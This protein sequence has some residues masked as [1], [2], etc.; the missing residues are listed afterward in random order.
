MT[1]N[2]KKELNSNWK[3][4]NNKGHKYI[5][6][7]TE[8]ISNLLDKHNIKNIDFCT[9]DTEGGEFDIIKSFD[10]DKYNVKIFV[11]ENNYNETNIKKYLESKGYK[12]ITK[13]SIDDVFI[14]QNV[15]GW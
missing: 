4:K 11:I 5:T 7:K 14:K 13:L 2:I 1:Q 9:I 12:Y 6:V 10:L 8:K 15:K 3:H